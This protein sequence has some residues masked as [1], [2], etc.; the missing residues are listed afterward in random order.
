M[1]SRCFFPADKFSLYFYTGSISTQALLEP[2]Q[3]LNRHVFYNRRRFQKVS[4]E[5]CRRPC[6]LHSYPTLARLRESFLFSFETLRT[7]LIRF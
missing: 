3:P 1:F 2:F 7:E 4:N 6:G 5:V